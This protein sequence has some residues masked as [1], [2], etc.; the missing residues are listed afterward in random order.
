M[1]TRSRPFRYC[2]ARTRVQ[3]TARSRAPVVGVV[4][5]RPGGARVIGCI[6]HSVTNFRRPRPA[7]ERS[8]DS[9]AWRKVA[10]V[11]SQ[12]NDAA[13]RLPSR[14]GGGSDYPGLTHHLPPS[15][16]DTTSRRNSRP[17]T[18]SGF[19][20]AFAK[21]R[22]M[23]TGEPFDPFFDTSGI[24]EPNHRAPSLLEA[25]LNVKRN[26]A[27]GRSLLFRNTPLKQHVTMALRRVN[28]PF[29]FHWRELGKEI[30]TGD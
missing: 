29:R 6:R 10:I 17:P 18:R 26:N 16:R 23:L 7:F 19:S 27:H 22:A 24:S 12:S 11:R 4:R 25:S 13:E 2:A 14:F 8:R 9:V 21:R 15:L 5:S 20:L 3:G 28:G 1:Q 30:A